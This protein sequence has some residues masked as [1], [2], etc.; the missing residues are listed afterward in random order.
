MRYLINLF[1]AKEQS[2]ADRVMYFAFHYLRYILVITQFVVICV[3]FF[4]FKVDQD[5]VDLKDKLVQQEQIVMAVQPLL[6]EVETIN[7]KITNIG[8][9]LDKQTSISEIYGYFFTRLP[10]NISIISLKMTST[11]VE[12]DGVTEDVNSVKMFY[13]S[14]KTDQRFKNVDLRN[15]KK[16]DRGYEFSLILLNFISSPNDT[17]GIYR[18]DN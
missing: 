11:S 17:Q 7:T 13:E 10:Q 14:L 1:P 3:F 8:N 15:V 4:R 5:I 16:T 6:K 2:P 9:V 12:M 18:Q